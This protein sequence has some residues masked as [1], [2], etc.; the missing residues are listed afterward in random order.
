MK[1][2]PLFILTTAALFSVAVHA[3]SITVMKPYDGFKSATPDRYFWD[4]LPDA[5][6]AKGT[7]SGFLAYENID[8]VYVLN[9]HLLQTG[10]DAVGNLILVSAGRERTVEVIEEILRSDKPLL[11]ELSSDDIESGKEN[12]PA[13]TLLIK[14]RAGKV[15]I[16]NHFSGFGILESG[17]AYAVFR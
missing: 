13:L 4:S 15:M 14:T 5:P 8:E 10:G 7:L 3:D 12:G 9:N 2:S 6:K 1:I 16:F 17:D 11:P